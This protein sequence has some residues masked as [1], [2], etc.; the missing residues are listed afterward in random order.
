MDLHVKLDVSLLPEPHSAHFA[1]K[2]LLSGVDPRVSE[3]V[4][5]DPEGLVALLAFMGFLS[6]MLEFVGFQSLT[7]DKRLPT[8]VAG[9]GPLP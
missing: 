6:R 3:V 4:C 9:E 5:V 8:N 1:L 7:D 2:G